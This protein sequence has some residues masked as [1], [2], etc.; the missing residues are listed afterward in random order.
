MNW[1]KETARSL[2]LLIVGLV[3]VTGVFGIALM[4][5]TI[6]RAATPAEQKQVNALARSNNAC[7]ECHRDETPGIV[8]QFGTSTMAVADVVCQDCHEVAAGY[9]GSVEHEYGNVQRVPRG[10][11]GAVQ[12]E[13]PRPASIRGDDGD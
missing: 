11:G 8:E 3:S 7:V 4:A 1:I 6:G 9:P 12:R 10:A 2:R 5:L 13:P